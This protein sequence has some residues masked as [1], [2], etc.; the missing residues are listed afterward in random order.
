MAMGPRKGWWSGAVA[1]R[2][3]RMIQPRLRSWRGW[4][5]LGSAGSERLHLAGF[6]SGNRQRLKLLEDVYCPSRSD[7]V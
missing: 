5:L 2:G 4:S 3:D 7:I 6:G 1:A